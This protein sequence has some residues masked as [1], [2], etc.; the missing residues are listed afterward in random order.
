VPSTV[1]VTAGT[2]SS[3]V[4]LYS[5]TAGAATLVATAVQS[6]AT[7]ATAQV[8]VNFVAPVN[9][10]AAVSLQANPSV[11]P[12][13]GQSTIIATVVDGTSPIPNP[14]EGATVDFT[15]TDVTGGTLSAGSAVTN[16]LGQATVTYK[17]S[18][19]SSQPN[20]VTIQAT[21]AS[22]SAITSLPVNLTVGGQTAFLSLGT[23]N[24]VIEY[25]NTQY[26]LPYSVQAVDSSGNGLSGVTITFSVKSITYF[27]GSLTYVS[28]EWGPNPYSAQNCP[29]TE[30]YEYNGQIYSP[31]PSP[32][33]NGY[34]LTAIPGS[35]AATDVSSA[36]TSAGGSA[37]VNLIYPKNHALWVGVALTATAT[38]SGT[39]NSTTATFI[40]PGASADYTSQSSAPPGQTSPYGTATS[41]YP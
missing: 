26:E 24:T 5:T 27:M 29:A 16:A 1:T 11:V 22:N 28:P 33:P 39:Q 6:G 38:V 12:T 3:P 41:C 9:T 21:L 17:A 2:P 32:L 20:G 34:V 4:T 8:Q 23:G 30:V 37:T 10:A 25:S 18:S 36:V 40:L 13:Q 35:V 15:L 19:G 14:V 31:P 7:V